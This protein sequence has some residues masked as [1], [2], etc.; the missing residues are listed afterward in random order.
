M[1]E[2]AEYA[3]EK[4]V[5]LQRYLSRRATDGEYYFKSKFIAD[6][7]GLSAKQIGVLLRDLRVRAS[8]CTSRSGHTRGRRPGVWSVT[9][10]STF[11]QQ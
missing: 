9:T 6:E 7:V 11:G 4:R 3:D 2:S 5:H 1:S 8:S 10:E